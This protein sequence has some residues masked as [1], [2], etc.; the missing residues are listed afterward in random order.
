M[1][2]FCKLVVYKSQRKEN[3]S[4]KKKIIT[5]HTLEKDNKFQQQI[6]C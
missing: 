6:N 4:K 3:A 2:T 1:V 5:S